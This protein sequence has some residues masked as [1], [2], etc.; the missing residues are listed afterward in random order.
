MPTPFVSGGR[1]PLPSDSNGLGAHKESLITHGVSNET[2]KGDQVSYT[3]PPGPPWVRQLHH[4][5]YRIFTRTAARRSCGFE[6][7]V[8]TNSFNHTRLS[9]R[10]LTILILYRITSRATVRVGQE[11]TTKYKLQP[12]GAGSRRRRAGWSAPV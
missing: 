1:E 5:L 12:S 11:P 3:A 2:A 6:S 8:W 4:M 10:V 9:W 7:V